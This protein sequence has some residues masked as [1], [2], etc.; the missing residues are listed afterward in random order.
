MKTKPY[1]Q[2]VIRCKSIEERDK[3]ITEL[4][5]RGFSVI[6]YFEREDESIYAGSTSYDSA[7]GTRQRHRISSAFTSFGAVLR[8]DNDGR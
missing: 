3:R 5:T 2:T 8:R 7:D 1:F 6:R 4:V